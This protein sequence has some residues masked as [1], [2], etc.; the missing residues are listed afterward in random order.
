MNFN[1][2]FT[3]SSSNGI[4]GCEDYNLNGDGEIGGDYNGA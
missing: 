2:I 4:I 1:F 3:E